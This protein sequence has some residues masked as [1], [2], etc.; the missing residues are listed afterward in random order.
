MTVQILQFSTCIALAAAAIFWR[1]KRRSAEGA[2]KSLFPFI[3][4]AGLMGCILVGPFGMEAFVAYYS[5]ALHETD[6]ILFRL[7]GPY[8]W[9]YLTAFILPLLPVFG[10]LPPVG[11]RP[12]LMTVLAVL[13]MVPVVYAR[14]MF[15]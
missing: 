5:G 8:R 6:P 12:V 9:V 10:L 11:K 2:H 1:S 13:A 14:V 4:A 7:E 3:I 15:G